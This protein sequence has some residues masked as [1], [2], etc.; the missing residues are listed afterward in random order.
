MG[1]WC[2][3]SQPTNREIRHLLFSKSSSKSTRVITSEYEVLH[4]RICTNYPVNIRFDE[5]VLKTSFVFVF[6]RRLQ[7]V[8]IKTNMFAL[9]LRLQKTSWSRPIYS[10]WPYVFKASSRRFQNVLQKRLQDIFKT[11]RRRFCSDDVFKTSSRLLAKISSRRLQNVFKTSVKM[12]S[13]HF[14]DVFKTFSIHLQDVFNTSSRRLA[15]M[16]SR[17]FES[18][19]VSSG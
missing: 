7:D 10:S 17:C 13:R 18:C 6:R 9:A 14:Q 11:S 5:D 3:L 4:Y 1:K 8:L 15:R 12:S 16:P 19:F 2:C